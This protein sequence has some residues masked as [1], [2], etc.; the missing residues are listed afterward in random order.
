MK[1]VIMMGLTLLT[2]LALLSGCNG[3]ARKFGGTT[4]IKLPVGKKLVNV[5]WKENDIWYLTRDM[6]DGELAET[7]RFDED[8]NWGVLE[9]TVIIKESK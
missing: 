5:T 9:G 4:E 1:K 7:Y 8:S 2:V 6:K 3:A